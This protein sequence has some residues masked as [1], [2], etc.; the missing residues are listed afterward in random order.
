MGIILNS[1]T[2]RK[3]RKPRIRDRIKGFFGIKPN[4][5]II[6][7]PIASFAPNFTPKLSAPGIIMTSVGAIGRTNTG[8][9]KAA[10]FLNMIPDIKGTQIDDKIKGFIQE[11]PLLSG[12]LATAAVGTIGGVIATVVAKKKAAKKKGKGKGKAKGCKP[13]RKGR[14]KK[15]GRGTEAAFKRKGGKNVYY[16][17]TGQPYIKLASGQ[18]RFIKRSK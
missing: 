17:K 12:V 1:S 10:G 2:D 5:G 7:G 11:N 15:T 16:T 6:S 9:E 8:Q 14:K 4:P 13:R 3:S 18:A